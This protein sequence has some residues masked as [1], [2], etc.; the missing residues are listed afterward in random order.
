LSRDENA[1]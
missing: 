1:K